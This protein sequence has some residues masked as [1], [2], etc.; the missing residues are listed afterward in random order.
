M[1]TTCELCNSQCP[2]HQHALPF[3]HLEDDL[4]FH[5]ALA[6]LQ[7]NQRLN[8]DRLSNLRLNPLI[9]NHQ[10]PGN[11][12]IDPDSNFYCNNHQSSDYLF[13]DQFQERFKRRHVKNTFSVFHLNARSFHKNFDSICDYLDLLSFRFSILGFTETWLHENSP[14]FEIDCYK[15]LSN[16]RK[17]KAGGGVALYIHD[18]LEYILRNDLALDNNTCESLFIEIPRSGQKNIIVGVIYKPP[19]VD[20]ATFVD[21]FDIVLQQ[22]NQENKLNQFYKI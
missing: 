12:D 6:E 20:P 19:K 18:S 16:N 2:C 15:F 5:V 14:S 17:N 22:I 9:F 1:V 11:S 13:C 4:D 21:S 10:F 7:T 3:N 8:T